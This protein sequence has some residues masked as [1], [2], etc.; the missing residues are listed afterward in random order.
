MR[1][2]DHTYSETTLS[3]LL[4][5]CL[6]LNA[7]QLKRQLKPIYSKIYGLDYIMNNQKQNLLH[8]LAANHDFVNWPVLLKGFVYLDLIDAF[9]QTA[10][11][12]AV[13]NKNFVAIQNLVFNGA[14][15]TIEDEHGINPIQLA[16]QLNYDQGLAEL[17]KPFTGVYYIAKNPIRI[18]NIC[19]DHQSKDAFK[20]FL[21]KLPEDKLNTTDDEGYGIIHYIVLANRIDFLKIL[22]RLNSDTLN[23]KVD[24]NLKVKMEGKVKK[25]PIELATSCEIAEYLYANG[26]TF[27]KKSPT[28]IISDI[29]SRSSQWATTG[30]SIGISPLHKAAM[31]GDSNVI[32]SYNESKVDIV[33]TFKMTP[34]LYAIPG[35]QTQVISLLLEKGADPNFFTGVTTAFHYAALKGSVNVF[36]QLAAVVQPDFTKDDAMGRSILTC[37]VANGNPDLISTILSM[38]HPIDPSINMIMRLTKKFDDAKASFV[39]E[40]L[41]NYNFP[42]NYPY[43]NN[44]TM[45]LTAIETGRTQFAATILKCQKGK[46]INTYE[47]DPE[48][49]LIISVL[50]E[51]AEIVKLLL[52]AGV[53]ADIM[54]H[55]RPLFHDTVNHKTNLIRNALL[56]EHPELNVSVDQMGNTFLHRAAVTNCTEALKVSI[57]ELK[58]DI[59]IKNQAGITAL[60]YLVQRPSDNF[61]TN[62]QFLTENGAD[63]YAVNDKKQNILHIC[64]DFSNVTALQQLIGSNEENLLTDEQITT[65]LAQENIDGFS[66]LE[67]AAKRVNYKALNLISFHKQLPIFDSPLSTEALDKYLAKGFSPNACNKE[68]YSLLILSIQLYK[69]DNFLGL[70]LVNKLIKAKV[71]PNLPSPEGLMPIHYAIKAGSTDIVNTLMKVGANFLVEPIITAYARENNQQEILELV[72]LPEKHA[73]AIYELLA[74]QDNAVPILG[75]ICKN[76]R[77]FGGNQNILSYMEQVKFMHRLL[78]LFRKRFHVI[79]SELNLSTEIGPFLLYFVDAFLPLLSI[80]ASYETAISIIRGSP[81]LSQLLSNPSGHQKLC[82]DD[83]LIVPTQQFTYYPELI[84]A[85]INVMPS[86]HNDLPF[87]RKAQIKFAYIGRTVNERKLIAESQRELCTIKLI[88]RIND[89]KTTFKIDDMLLSRGQFERKIYKPPQKDFN[90][91]NVSENFDWGLRTYYHQ[92]GNFNIPYFGLIGSSMES[93]IGKTKIAIYLFRNIVLFGIQKNADQFKLKFSCRSSEVLWDFSKENGPNAVMLYAPFGSMLLKFAP[94]KGTSVNFE[95]NR[96]R[97]DVEK[98]AIIDEADNPSPNGF[99]ICYASWVSAS[100]NC[101]SSYTFHVKCATKT[102]AK[103]KILQALTD[104]GI[105]VLAKPNP[106]INYDFQTLKTNEGQESDVISDLMSQV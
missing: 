8:V 27:N 47:F 4:D 96:W 32:K 46:K 92:V 15:T 52:Q 7:Q 72:K 98:L 5:L 2:T 38:N 37:A 65:L 82:L 105:K 74:I 67:F 62:F 75:C 61:R 99:E 94:P 63:I 9:Q 102:E 100:S 71:D 90:P 59:N 103:E 85:I 50:N 93:F 86:E 79:Y 14:S 42:L 30:V 23:P 44:K 29:I 43:E 60:H 28:P 104:N 73:S 33:D 51:Y 76:S 16:C 77:T 24:I 58:I 69:T 18:A 70:Q 68:G 40:V 26:A 53:S 11:Y 95:R 91:Q 35:S 97:S 31:E 48:R 89:R 41:L 6:T 25:T 36:K 34:L 54:N 22:L 49:C 64:A 84:K 13:N 57:N 10:L 83:V 106:L 3:S 17:T 39:Y 66:P 21:K 78:V 81:K 87:L 45:L 19:I 88:T 1:K 101:V 56:A 80:A 20:V 55:G 12:I